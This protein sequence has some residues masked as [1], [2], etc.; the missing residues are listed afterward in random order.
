MGKI[1]KACFA[2][3]KGLRANMVKQK[4]VDVLYSIKNVIAMYSFDM[5]SLK[6]EEQRKPP[7]MLNIK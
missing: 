1:R 3:K 2:A 6:E 7:I 4:Q 5:Y